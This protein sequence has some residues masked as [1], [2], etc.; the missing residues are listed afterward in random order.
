MFGSTVRFQ[1]RHLRKRREFQPEKPSHRRRLE[2]DRAVERYGDH[3]RLSRRVRLL[4]FE[5]R[6]HGRIASH[7]KLGNHRQQRVRLRRLR[8]R[9]KRERERRVSLRRRHQSRRSVCR[10]R[11]QYERLRILRRRRRRRLSRPNQYQRSRVRRRRRRRPGLRRRSRRSRR[12]RVRLSAI[13]VRIRGLSRKFILSRRRLK[14]GE[15][16]ILSQPMGRLILH[17]RSRLSRRRLVNRRS[18][19]R[20]RK[21]KLLSRLHPLKR[22]SGRIRGT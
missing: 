11:Q 14:P 18:R 17:R 12:R 21:R 20:R 6:I 9:R 10:N 13:S 4:P 5:S 7:G 2:P 16:L 22:M 15:Q 8:K 3:Q 19:M 1:L